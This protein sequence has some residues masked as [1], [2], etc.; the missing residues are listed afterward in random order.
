MRLD[1]ELPKQAENDRME[2]F[3]I[4]CKNELAIF[5]RWISFTGPLYQRHTHR[6]P[7]VCWFKLNTSGDYE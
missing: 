7:L 2:Q 4:T 5:T 6:C 3:R 1:V